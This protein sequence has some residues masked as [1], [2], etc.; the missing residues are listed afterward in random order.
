[1]AVEDRIESLRRQHADL[2]R[3]V[4]LENARLYPDDQRLKDLK[5]K[6]LYVKEEIH[7]IH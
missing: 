2:D 7:S 3:Q 1:M 4:Q 5:L 6:K